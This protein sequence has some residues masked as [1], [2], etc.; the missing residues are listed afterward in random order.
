MDTKDIKEQVKR[1]VDKYQQYYSSGGN[2]TLKKTLVELSKDLSALVKILDDNATIVGL[3]Y[4]D[5]SLSNLKRLIEAEVNKIERG[6]IS[7][8]QAEERIGYLTYI[9]IYLLKLILKDKHEEIVS[10]RTDGFGINLNNM[11]RHTRYRFSYEGS[12]Y[13][14]IKNEEGE[15]V[16]SEVV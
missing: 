10:I 4:S 11:E 7:E 1:L 16:L 14:A 6:N 5:M 8:W 3:E 2:K 15:L 9:Y 13:E 12:E